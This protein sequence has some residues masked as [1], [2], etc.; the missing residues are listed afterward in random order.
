MFG[1]AAA[2]ALFFPLRVALAQRPGRPGIACLRVDF[3]NEAASQ[4]AA[5]P[6][7]RRL[8]NGSVL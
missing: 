1:A 2:F 3:N 4:A 8:P 7:G 6:S 5:F